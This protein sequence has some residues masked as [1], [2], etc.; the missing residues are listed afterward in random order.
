[1]KTERAFWPITPCPAPRQVAADKWK[2]GRDIRGPV[3]R[4]RAFRDEVKLR[5]VWTPGPGDLVVFL[6]PIPKSRVREQLDGRPHEQ[7]P[8]AD[9]LLKALLD[10]VL[11]D[12]S[13]VWTITPAKVW[14]LTPGIFIERRPPA[15]ALPFKLPEGL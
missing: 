12:D 9:N 2:R 7:V 14:S 10:A 15:I 11:D 3:S 1:M 8:D 5:R 13:H 4:Y 6:M